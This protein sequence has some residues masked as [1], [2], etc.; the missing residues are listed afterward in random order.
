PT[1]SDPLPKP[2]RGEQGYEEFGFES[3]VS[4]APS[5][6]RMRSSKAPTVPGEM[7]SEQNLNYL[8]T[9][10]ETV[11]D[12]Q[13]AA[14]RSEDFYR[15]AAEALVNL[16]GLDYGLVLLQENG[17]WVVKGSA[18]AENRKVGPFSR[19]LVNHVV[20]NRCTIY[21]DINKLSA[22]SNS[23]ADIDAAVV[24][25][26]F[27][28]DESV[29]GVMYGVRNQEGLL[30]R[31]NVTAIESHLVQ[32]LAGAA[33]AYLARSAALRNQV[34]FEQFFAS[35]LVRELE[36]DPLLLEGR[37]EEVT[38]LC[39]DLRGFT[40]LSQRLGAEKTCRMLRDMM[41]VLSE[42]IVEAGGTIVDYAG[43]GILAMW[44]AP[45]KQPRHVELA[46]QAALAMLA[47]LPEL[48]ERWAD[49]AG[50][51]LSLGIGINTGDAQVGNTGSSRKFKYGPHGHTVNLA[52][53]IQDA[54]KALGLPLLIAGKSRESL[55]A[56]FHTRRVGSIRMPGVSEPVTVFE[57]HG[58]EASPA[59]LMRRDIYERALQFFETAQLSQACQAAI[60]LLS[61]GD[62]EAYDTPALKMLRRVWDAMDRPDEPFEPVIDVGAK[63]P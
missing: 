24:S 53:R 51:T 14:A 56:E 58:K 31:G 52:S 38:I 19:S 11:A 55:P 49:D 57:L 40:S 35:D 27:G 48:N 32:L 44:N 45:A 25:P 61:I 33:G 4:I 50:G 18:A 63:R 36:R 13:H 6:S 42:R 10:L 54:T 5:S 7:S 39:S 2:I 1:R 21:R 22:D 17:T 47:E 37:I 26:I 28:I 43:D 15:L 30:A 20:V 62:D 29:K 16:I 60:P 59:W 8:A 41:E 3:M 34:Q 12:L 46:C 23:M 9:W